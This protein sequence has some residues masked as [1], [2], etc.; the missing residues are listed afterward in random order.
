MIARLWAAAPCGGKAGFAGGRKSALA[1]GGWAS[2][3]QAEGGGPTL[4]RGRSQGPIVDHVAET[5]A[6]LHQVAHHYINASFQP[7]QI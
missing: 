7:L 3:L 2:A 4:C 6:K 1:T 5:A